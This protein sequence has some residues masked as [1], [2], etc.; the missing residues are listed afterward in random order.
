MN[1]KLPLGNPPVMVYQHHAYTLSIASLHPDFEHWVNCNFIQLECFTD[2][3]QDQNTPINFFSFINFIQTNPLVKENYIERKYLS[4]HVN[5]LDFFIQVIM[6][7]GY[8][9][10]FINKYYVPGSMV[11]KKQHHIHDLLIYGCDLSRKV[12]NV[13]GYKEDFT[14]GYS[15][16]SF[17]DFVRAFNSITEGNNSLKEWAQG[18]HVLTVNLQ[19]SY[20]FD[21][22]SMLGLLED[23]LYSRNTALR[24]G[25]YRNPPGLTYGLSTY[26]EVDRYL[27]EVSDPSIDI[28]IFH[29][30]YEHKKSM[31]T[32]MEY[33]LSKGILVEA[34][35]LEEYRKLETLSLNL[36][37]LVVKLKMNGQRKDMNQLRIMLREIK[38]R[39]EAVLTELVMKLKQMV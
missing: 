29:V 5:F 24:F 17:D 4:E 39:E 15:E 37:N 36:R 19:S 14:Y 35:P 13:A 32:R 10:T 12:F 8:V 38:D 30:I 16:I 2:S 23:Y 20:R 7:Q 25:M 1:I 27:T 34:G 22:S 31:R 33:L 28:R 9:M 18:M 3:L 11:Y 26:K 6:Q 21:L